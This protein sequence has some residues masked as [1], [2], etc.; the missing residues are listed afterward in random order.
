[1]HLVREHFSSPILQYAEAD[2]GKTFTLVECPSTCS[3]VRLS[4]IHSFKFSFSY[5]A[6][7]AR[8]LLV[9]PTTRSMSECKPF[10]P[11]E[12][13]NDVGPPCSRMFA[14]LFQQCL[15]RSSY[16][17]DRQRLRRIQASWKLCHYSVELV[18][19]T[20]RTFLTEMTRG[21]C[22]DRA[23]IT[24]KNTKYESI[25]DLRDTTI[26]ISRHGR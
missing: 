24:G 21:S 9:S 2:G 15:D 10:R 4:F 13:E 16:F 19:A 18:R 20:A 11:M 6:E 7:R 22:L 25:A 12:V 3:G 1:M 23:V 17:W 26:G 14:N 8:L 5:K